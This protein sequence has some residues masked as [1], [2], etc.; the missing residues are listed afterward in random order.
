M[1]TAVTEALGCGFIP[2]APA[3]LAALRTRLAR[4]R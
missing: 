4:R 3:E 1:A 2:R